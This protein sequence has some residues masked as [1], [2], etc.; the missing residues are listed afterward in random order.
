M[1]SQGSDFVLLFK[2]DQSTV[3]CPQGEKNKNKK[4]AS[5]CLCLKHKGELTY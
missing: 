2:Q 4:N 1:C 5:F 3:L